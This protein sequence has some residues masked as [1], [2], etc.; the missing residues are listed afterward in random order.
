MIVF[1]LMFGFS[2]NMI[3]I[4]VFIVMI[5]GGA[6]FVS[7]MWRQVQNDGTAYNGA[8]RSTRPMSRN[9]TWS[10]HH[11]YNSSSSST[12]DNVPTS[13]S[14]IGD[15]STATGGVSKKYCP[16]CGATAIEGDVFCSECGNKLV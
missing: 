10:K 4:V 11:S 14:A 16:T 8:Y 15:E 3:G 12:E 2:S 5:V 9:S 1:M 6:G 13:P 7:Y